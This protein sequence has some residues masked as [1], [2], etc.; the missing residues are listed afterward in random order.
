M[1]R[2][3]LFGGGAIL[4]CAILAVLLGSKAPVSSATVVEEQPGTGHCSFANNVFR[5]EGRA[6]LV[7]T[8]KDGEKLVVHGPFTAQFGLEAR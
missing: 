8:V 3:V 6:E 5:C 4:A 2:L 7:V 1:T